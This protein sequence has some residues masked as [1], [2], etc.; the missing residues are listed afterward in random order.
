MDARDLE[1]CERQLRALIA[2]Y[3][4][5]EIEELAEHLCVWVV[6]FY[7]TIEDIEQ[8]PELSVIT[9]ISSGIST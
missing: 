8:V 4:R 6:W 2:E 1:C 7:E 3:G 5:D 9:T